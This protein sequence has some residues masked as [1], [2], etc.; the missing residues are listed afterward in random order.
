MAIKELDILKIDNV[1]KIW[2]E[3]NIIAHDFISEDYWQSN[4]DFV[5]KVLPE[6]TV[7]VYE[8]NNEIRGF[9]GIVDN[10]Y[11]AGLF[12]KN[13]W[14]SKG[15]GSKLIEKCKDLYPTLILD[16][17]GKNLKAVKFYKKHG[18]KIKEEKENEETKEIE[19]SMIWKR[20]KD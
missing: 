6:S 16:V 9:I 1:M 2:L 5:K 19:Y 10:S 14:Q 20:L 15:I 18:F 12:V 7:L 3:S 11:I 13:Q 8:D 4:Y 17:Y